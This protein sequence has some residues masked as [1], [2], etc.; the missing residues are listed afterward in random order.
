MKTEKILNQL[1]KPLVLSGAYK[2]ETVA[3]KD[4]VATQIEKKIK[5]YNRTALL[6]KA[7]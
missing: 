4:I 5:S 2:D 6:H 7:G 3:L 1:I